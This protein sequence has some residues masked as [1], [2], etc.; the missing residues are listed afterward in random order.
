[1]AVYMAR[2]ARRTFTER[3]AALVRPSAR[4]TQRLTELVARV[5]AALGGEAG[6]RLL[7]TLD[8]TASADTVLRE[9]RRAR[10]RRRSQPPG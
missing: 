3:L 10:P 7:P 9:V 1:M 6:A 4:R 2:C 8:A 5:G